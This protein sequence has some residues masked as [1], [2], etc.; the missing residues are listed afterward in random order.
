[1]ADPIKIKPSHVGLFTEKARRNG[2][3]VAQYASHVLAPNSNASGATKKQA[4]F[5]RN[6]AGWSHKK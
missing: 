1:M 3:S 5:A 6:A 4:N 2:M